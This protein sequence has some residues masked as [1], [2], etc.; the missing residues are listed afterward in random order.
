MPDGETNHEFGEFFPVFLGSLNESETS[1]STTEGRCY[2]NISME[3]K[4]VDATTFEL[5]LKL[6]GKKSAL[7]VENILF[8][9]TEIFHD[10]VF[11]L[12]GSRKITFD[13]SNPDTAA[14]VNF[15]GIHAFLFC[16][17]IVGEVESIVKSLS[18][19]IGGLGPNPDI[20]FFGSHVPEYMEKANIE[21]LCQAM[22]YCMVEREIQDL[23][24]D[25][26]SS[27][28]KKGDFFPVQRMD[29]LD[30]IVMYGSGSH[31]GHS[32]MAMRFEEDPDQLYIVESQAAWYWPTKNLQR[33]K[34]ETWIQQAKNADFNVAWLPMRE[35]VREA[36]DW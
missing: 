19:F 2:E 31:S 11:V 21:F 14:D 27:L 5:D 30:E 7:C 17:G 9:N 1:V 35:E 22:E 18:A 24:E 15:N 3:Y 12:P 25:F 6:S 8:A 23:S 34:W 32:V 20:P 26:D 36:A 13:M 33:T 10:E 16:D 4:Q 29:G 28:I